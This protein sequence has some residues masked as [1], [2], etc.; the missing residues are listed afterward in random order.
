MFEETKPRIVKSHDINL[1]SDYI[2][3]IHDVKQRYISTQI[4]AAVK[5]NTERLYFNW[6]LGR[7][8]VERKAEEKWGKGIVEQL[9]LRFTK[10][11]FL[12]KNG[13]SA[14]NLWNMKKSGTLFYS[15]KQISFHE[16]DSYD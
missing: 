9:S 10:M 7:D 6:Q 2:N 13:F 15:F 1:D 5:V 3:W 14:R 16:M 4:K 8:L 11:N 12:M